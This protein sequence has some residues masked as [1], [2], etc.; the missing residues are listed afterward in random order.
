[1]PGYR[2][3]SSDSHIVEPPNLWTGRI[4]AR[5]RDRC[6]QLV[7]IDGAEVWVCDN[8]RAQ[9]TSQGSNVGKRF[10]DPDSITVADVFESVSPGEYDP[11]EHV[12]DL[13]TDGVDVGIVYPTVGFGNFRAPNCDLR[14]AIFKAYNDFAAEFCGAHPKRLGGIGMINVEDVP[15]AVRELERSRNMGMVGA[16]IASY[17]PQFRTYDSP[18]YDPFWAA[19]QD[20]EVPISL[21]AATNAWGAA[22][23]VV[24]KTGRFFQAR[25]ANM[26]HYARM[27][28][29]EMTYGGVFERFP[30][31]RVGAVEF[32]LG[33]IPYF[34]DRIDFNYTQRGT[35]RNRLRFKNDMLPSDFFR[36]N[37]FAGS[38]EDALGIR[39]RHIIGVDALLSGFDYPHTESTFP[40][41]REII[42]DILTEC[43][44]EEKAKIAGGNA[45]RIYKM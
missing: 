4:E 11:D 16:M 21:H 29:A 22:D 28:L 9:Q 27:A 45:A 39:D 20:L 1:M 3:I 5:Y 35:G 18:D 10:E 23:Q 17:A 25:T 43:T 30:G 41:S 31:L 38:Q 34:L 32:E 7:E 14:T 40:R 8:V 33:W 13:D 37:C 19:A 2:V 12:K 15:G 42:E 44:D 36:G 6:P 24:P 26:D